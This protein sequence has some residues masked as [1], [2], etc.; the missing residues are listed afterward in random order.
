MAKKSSLKIKC[1]FLNSQLPCW[2]DG[3]VGRGG[4]EMVSRGP[5][6]CLP[7]RDCLSG[8]G[9][10]RERT[11]YGS[12]CP[13]AVWLTQKGSGL[14][15]K[16]EQQVFSAEVKTPP[17][18]SVPCSCQRASVP[19]SRSPLHP[20]FLCLCA[21]ERQQVMVQILGWGAGRAVVGTA[22]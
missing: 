4:A 21:L 18:T 2:D 17:G 5:S 13:V 7:L 6:S 19:K 9:P 15:S 12:V 8:Q 14:K 1:H 10:R 16:V 20:S 22:R 11:N 3:Y